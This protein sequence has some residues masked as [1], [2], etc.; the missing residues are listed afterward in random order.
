METMNRFLDALSAT[1]NR[2][3]ALVAGLSEEALSYSPGPDVFSLLE[4]VL[5]LRDIDGELKVALAQ[6]QSSTKTWV[7]PKGH[8]EV[9]ESIEQAAL[10]EIFE[11]AGLANVQLIK[12]LGSLLRSSVKS[13]GDVV[14]KTIH[15]YL[16]YAVGFDVPQ[17]PSDLAFAE[18]GWFSP[19]QAMELLPYE[20]ERVFFQ[21]HLSPLLG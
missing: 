17:T 4:N 18:V 2:V 9:G 10:R 20:A 6:H 7:L 14:H 16:A 13:N 5:H 15:Y 19:K 12:L 3:R 8:V 21:E 1:P 11:E